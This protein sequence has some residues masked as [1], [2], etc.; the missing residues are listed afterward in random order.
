MRWQRLDVPVN[1]RADQ[2]SAASAGLARAR[3]ASRFWILN[4]LDAVTCAYSWSAGAES[5]H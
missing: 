3:R 5:A 2:V 4:W 1:E